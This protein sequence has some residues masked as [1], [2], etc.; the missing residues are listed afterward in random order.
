MTTI[1]VVDGE[2]LPS[3]GLFVRENGSLLTGLASG[4]TF[5]MK[6]AD[7]DGTVVFTKTTGVT[8]QTG[9]GVPPNGTP[10][11]VVQWNASPSELAALSGGSTYAAQLKITR[12]SDSRSRYYQFTVYCRAA[13]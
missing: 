12:T 4:H 2:S 11:V 8:G 6:I 7:S 1:E 10:N 9:S 5:E 3:L 13:L